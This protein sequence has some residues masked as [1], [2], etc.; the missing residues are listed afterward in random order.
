MR[1]PI[2]TLTLDRVLTAQLVVA[3]AGESGDPEDPESQRLGWWRTDLTNE[4]GGASFFE[5]LLPSTAAWAGFEAARE[6]A[7]RHDDANRNQIAQPDQ[8]LTLF[9][10]GFHADE[11]IDERM[12]ELKRSGQTPAEA[13]PVLAEIADEESWDAEEFAE[14]LHA[15]ASPR[16]EVEPA[17]RRVTGAPPADVGRLVA[18][19]LGAMVPLSDG[20]P[21]PHY[22]QTRR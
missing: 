12:A 19:L 20:F 7:R 10:L 2:P 14:W 3:W 15:Q 1:N 5:D 8:F 13:L 16:V 11:R 22:R 18:N 21:M 4:F 17:G 9:R 6:A